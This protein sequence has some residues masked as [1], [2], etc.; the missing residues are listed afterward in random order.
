MSRTAAIAMVVVGGASAAPAACS[1][2]SDLLTTV[3]NI[4]PKCFEACPDVCKPLDTFITEFTTSGKVTKDAICSQASRLDC[5]FGDA[6]AECGKVLSMSSSTGLDLPTSVAQ[7][8][9]YKQKCGPIAS[10][11]SQASKGFLSTTAPAK[12]NSTADSESEEVAESTEHPE[13]S[14]RSEQSEHSEQS[15]QSEQS[16]SHDTDPM[17]AT[18]QS[19][20]SSTAED[21]PAACNKDNPAV[22]FVMS[23]APTC[24]VK[25]PALCAAVESQSSQMMGGAPDKATVKKQVCAS[26]DIFACAVQ[27][28]HLADC[29]AVLSAGSQYGLPETSAD[30]GRLCG[31]G[32]NDTKSEDNSAMRFNSLAG[33][34]AAIL[35]WMV[36]Q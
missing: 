32:A 1:G 4:A 18:N 19:N 36:V 6:F 16:E 12:E 20:A 28:A 3:V 27:A 34:S 13:Q 26:Q 5:A 15:E 11:K 9:S 23:L 30:L 29:Q 7:W 21:T 17:P 24:F 2:G 25:C 31:Q 35:G 14:E 33:L 22:S 10:G 8:T